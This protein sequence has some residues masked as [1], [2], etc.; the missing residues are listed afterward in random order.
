MKRLLLCLT[1]IVMLG[2]AFFGN[3]ILNVM[4]E[5]S[6]IPYLHSYYKSI[7]IEEGDTLW[8]IAQKYKSKSGLTTS[9]YVVE[10]KNMNNLKEDTIHSGHYLTVVY[11]SEA[12]DED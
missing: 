12:P 5:E 9:Q 1:L 11:Y 7:R 10:L 2:S 4:A 8:K 6:S 3:S